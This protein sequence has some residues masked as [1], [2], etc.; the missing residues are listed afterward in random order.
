M[1]EMQKRKAI[2]NEDIWSL[3]QS[4]QKGNQE[5]FMELTQMYQKKVFILAYSFFR[6]KEDALD[7]VQET[8]LRLFQKIGMFRRGENFEAWLLQISKNLCVDFY[9][10]NYVRRRQLES[11]QRVEEL[12]L[13]LAQSQDFHQ[14]RE[15]GEILSRCVEK[16]AEKQRMIFVMRHYN[17]LKNEEIAQIL[18]ISLGT[19]K[20][21]HFKAIRNLRA[22]MS[23]FLGIQT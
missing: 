21:L 6:N 3:V 9:R 11:G 5:A 22:R 2:Q 7:L 12:N 23:P 8:F 16:L 14:S 13:P 15:F 20:S 19:V 4:V 17:Q 18:N 10:R 1:P